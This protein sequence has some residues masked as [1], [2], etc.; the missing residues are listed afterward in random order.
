MIERI[1][2][3]PDVHL[4]TK[5]PKEYQ[6]VKKFIKD[7][8]PDEVILLGDFMEVEA[9][10]SYDLSKKRKIEGKRFEKEMQ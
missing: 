10:S 6:L 4:T 8:K 5:I 7:Y 3:L 2:V 9:L 1:V